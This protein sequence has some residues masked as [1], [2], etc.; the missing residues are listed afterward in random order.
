MSR[1][2]LVTGATGFI[3]KH[4]IAELLRRGYHVRGTVRDLA[5]AGTVR[6]ALEAAAVDGAALEL[7]A[8]DLTGDAGW[9]NA[10]AGVG[11]VLHVASPFPMQLPRDR[12]QVVGPARQGTLRVLAAATQAGVERVVVTSSMVACVYPSDG[13]QARTYTEADWTDADRADISAYV[14]SKTLAELAAWDFV[15]ATGGAPELVVLN[16]GFVQGPA[17]DADLSTS[18]EVLRVL[19]TGKYPAVPKAG[20]A[21]VDVRDLAIAHAVSLHL[22]SAAGQR[23]LIANGFLTF[24]EIGRYMCEALPDISRRVPTW[25]APDF[26]LR[27][28]SMFDRSLLA[29]LPDLSLARR[30]ENAKAR[31][32]LGLSFRSPGEAITSATLSLRRLG[33]I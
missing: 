19:A 18:H 32:V 28:L 11:H 23:F 27:G 20:F 15:R 17:L 29:L 10:M 25:E 30:C 24:R 13:V 12:A 33:V 8:A 31:E 22:P 21:I 5:R 2:I 3:A 14:A 9:D 16:P 6:A 4:C 26:V 1:R 7:V